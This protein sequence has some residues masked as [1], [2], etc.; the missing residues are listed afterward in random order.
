MKKIIF[1]LTIA[2]GLSAFSADAQ[3]TTVKKRSHK[4]K[5]TAI[6]AGVGAATGAI[7]AGKGHRGKG[8]VIGGVAGGA[9]GYG[10]GAHKDRKYGK[11]TVVKT[12]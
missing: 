10:V 8:A 7:V 4:G 11:R 12:K 5:S 2:F 9:I 1:A 6:G 3:T